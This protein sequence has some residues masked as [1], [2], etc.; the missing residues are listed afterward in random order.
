LDD[1]VEDGWWTRCPRDAEVCGQESQDATDRTTADAGLYKEV[2]GEPNHIDLRPHGHGRHLALT[3][4]QAGLR[5]LEF[6]LGLSALGFETGELLAQIAIGIAALRGFG[7]PLVA[8]VFDFGK[9][10]HRVCSLTSPHGDR[11]WGEVE[12][13]MIAEERAMRGT[14]HLASALAT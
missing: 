3:L 8:A 1:P 5:L 2:Q 7:F 13:D 9:W 4:A 10:T 14:G 11:A 12:M 6:L